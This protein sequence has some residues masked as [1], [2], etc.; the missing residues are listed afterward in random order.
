MLSTTICVSFAITFFYALW[1]GSYC[2]KNS[3]ANHRIHCLDRP[4]HHRY[5]DPIQSAKG[6]ARRKR[7]DRYRNVRIE[8]TSADFDVFRSQKTW[9]S[10]Y[11]IIFALINTLLN[12]F[13][14]KF[15]ILEVLFRFFGASIPYALYAPLILAVW[16]GL[17]TVRDGFSLKATIGT[18]IFAAVATYLPIVI[19]VAG[20]FY[21]KFRVAD[22]PTQGPFL[23][24]GF[25]LLLIATALGYKYFRKFTVKESIL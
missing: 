23:F 25:I 9:N 4:F 22:V 8:C 3:P 20:D 19:F 15:E 11:I 24:V 21:P 17:M 1:V 12:L 10:I 13:A 16:M 7:T 6:H 18:A 5:A 14:C 2:K